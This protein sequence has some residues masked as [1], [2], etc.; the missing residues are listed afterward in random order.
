MI[1]ANY[2]YI[3][4]LYIPLLMI[5][6]ITGNAVI[7]I[8]VVISALIW[9]AFYSKNFKFLNKYFK[10]F[11]YLYLLFY[12]TLVISSFFSDYFEYSFFKSI[13][14]I[15]FIFFGLFLY[16][17]Y[18]KRIDSLNKYLFS[19][20]VVLLLLYIDSLIQFFYGVNLFG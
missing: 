20:V 18:L 9:I 14:F 7:D 3:Y 11:I 8:I 1:L 6:F 10:C 5:A 19:I 15:R 4:F 17:F 13:F 12:L 16:T 2:N